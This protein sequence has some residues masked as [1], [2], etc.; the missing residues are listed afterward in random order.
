MKRNKDMGVHAIKVR[1]REREKER[2]RER[3][4]E[5]ERERRERK[6]REGER[7]I[8]TGSVEKP[9]GSRQRM[10]IRR[11]TSPQEKIRVHH[12]MKSIESP[13]RT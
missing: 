8:R 5:K 1:K 3:E 9:H 13:W 2:E 11:Q 6:E 7:E 4:K 10:C 12:N